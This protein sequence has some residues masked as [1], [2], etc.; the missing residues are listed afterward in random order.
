MIDKPRQTSTGINSAQLMR[1]LIFSDRSTDQR[2]DLT[3]ADPKGG[4]GRGPVPPP[5]REG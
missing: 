5:S 2:I 3:W 1:K 4:G